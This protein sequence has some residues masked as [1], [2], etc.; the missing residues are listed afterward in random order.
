MIVVSTKV[1]LKPG[2]A[3]ECA[4]LFNETNPAL[5]RNQPN[6][7]GATMMVDRD[8][9]TITVNAKWKD[10]GSYR[11][12]AEK[13]DFQATMARFASLFAGPPQITVLELL[14]D[15]QPSEF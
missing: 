7:L 10:E 2:L 15:M 1:T 9:E 13:P 11:A 5:V 6:W 14:V 3:D 4:R 8:T 12:M